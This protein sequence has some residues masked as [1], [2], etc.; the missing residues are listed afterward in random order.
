M[1]LVETF[2]QDDEPAKISI[3]FKDG[4]T[5]ESRNPEDVLRDSFIQSTRIDEIKLSGSNFES[6]RTNDAAVIFQREGSYPIRFIVAGKRASTLEFERDVINELAASKQW[7]SPLVLSFFPWYL[8]GALVSVSILG[9]AI[10]ASS[11]EYI[12]RPTVELFFY[13]FFMPIVLWPLSLLFLN[14]AFPAIIFDLGDGARRQRRRTTIWSF[15]IGSVVVALL[16]GLSGDFLKD[17]LT[18]GATGTH[19]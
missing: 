9:L 16:V 15:V 7:Y 6:K 19:T 10:A 14:A 13:I 17:W 12:T 3:T 18:R 4:R 5:M 1:Q 2:A 8:L 11:L